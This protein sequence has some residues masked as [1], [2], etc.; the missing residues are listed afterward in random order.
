MRKMNFGKNLAA[1]SCFIITFY[2]I[3]TFE[4]ALRNSMAIGSSLSSAANLLMVTGIVI[5]ASCLLL[6]H[7]IKISSQRWG[8]FVFLFISIICVANATIFLWDFGVFDG[9]QVHFSDHLFKALLEVLFFIATAFLMVKFRYRVDI[10]YIKI[11]ICLI[12]ITLIPFASQTK[13]IKNV[14]GLKIPEEKYRFDLS[15]ME[16]LNFSSKKNIIIF[17]IDSLQTDIFM[18]ALQNNSKLIKTFQGFTCFLNN[19]GN[20]PNTTFAVPAMVSGIPYKGDIPKEKYIA[21]VLNGPTSLPVILRQH[22]YDVRLFTMHTIPYQPGITKWD[23][24]KNDADHGGAISAWLSLTRLAMYK[25]MAMPIK[26]FLRDEKRFA[27]FE[28]YLVRILSSE[29]PALANRYDD[30]M[31]L[32]RLIKDITVSNSI[33]VMRWFHFQGIHH[34]LTLISK[35]E[36]DDHHKA[37]NQ[38]A[39]IQADRLLKLFSE[40]L[41]AFR[42]F[43]I[44]NDATIAVLGDHGRAEQRKPVMLIK[45]AGASSEFLFNEAPTSNTD[46]T[47]TLLADAGIKTAQEGLDMFNID[48]EKK[49]KRNYYA[50]FSIDNVSGLPKKVTLQTLNIPKNV[51]TNWVTTSTYYPALSARDSN[52]DYIGFTCNDQIDSKRVRGNYIPGAAGITWS[53]WLELDIPTPGGCAGLVELVYYR[54]KPSPKQV[55]IFI[56][57]ILYSDVYT[58]PFGS[59]FFL[60]PSK[61]AQNDNIETSTV[62]FSFTPNNSEK[63][64]LIFVD[65]L[66]TRIQGEYKSMLLPENSGINCKLG[67]IWGS[68]GSF[69]GKTGR[70]IAVVNDHITPVTINNKKK[71][72]SFK[73]PDNMNENRL[74]YFLMDATTAIRGPI[75]KLAKDCR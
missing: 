12:I 19:S 53:N 6:L 68:G 23:N 65:L 24:I 55:K 17:V 28:D 35:E 29:K 69:W 8:R 50:F 18:Q 5:W 70:L 2:L 39:Q 9:S 67:A 43:G 38:L 33:P 41:L 51:A 4:S 14:L 47:S 48:P 3:P 45:K 30:A 63:D 66:S 64:T 72:F 21:K 13:S 60:I 40:M 75:V 56:D 58:A 74:E 11:C 34:P 71:F 25:V 22:G 73:I 44:Y 42:R 61:T 1:S 46:L 15:D 52:T 7:F 49:R 27:R 57:G 16:I 26:L 32:N 59:I 20:S 10:K 54:Y 36:Q 37:V 31:L 62:R